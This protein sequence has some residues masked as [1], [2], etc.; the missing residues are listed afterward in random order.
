MKKMHNS[1][2]D[3]F[4]NRSTSIDPKFKAKLRSQLVAASKQK[5]SKKSRRWP[6]LLA[7]P[8]LAA[9]AVALLIGLNLSGNTD[10]KQP[11]KPSRV[12]AAELIRRVDSASESWQGAYTFF[13]YRNTLLTGPMAETCDALSYIGQRGGTDLTYGY[14][15]HTGK[16]EALFNRQT[17]VDGKPD[18]TLS[19][20]DDTDK[21]IFDDKQFLGAPDMKIS[22]YF[23]ARDLANDK[24]AILPI[25]EKGDVVD[26]D[27]FMIEPTLQDGREV[28]VFY[29][30]S[31]PEAQDGKVGCW[32]AGSNRDPKSSVGTYSAPVYQTEIV[33]YVIDA[34]TNY[35]LSREAYLGSI[36]PENLL[37]SETTERKYEYKTEAEALA[38]MQAAGFDK[39]N[40]LSKIPGHD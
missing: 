27:T 40:A 19:M 1:D 8:T 28:Y 12:S 37:N 4:S 29:T 25:N 23:E 2:L 31:N 7:V 34:K 36:A 11:L 18:Y 30:M 39:Q 22:A 6:A 21:Q 33:R 26:L 9:V 35:Q 5:S 32:P 3:M 14:R 10:P 38:I 15:D 24:P 16:V 17:Y 20:Y 13:S